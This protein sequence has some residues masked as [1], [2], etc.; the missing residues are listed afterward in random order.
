VVGKEPSRRTS[1][2]A[3]GHQAAKVAAQHGKPA[4]SGGVG[5]LEVAIGQL[6]RSAGN[7]ATVALLRKG[8]G[9]SDAPAAAKG[10]PL[11][12][13]LRQGVEALSGLSMDHVRVHYNSPVPAQLQAL[14]YSQGSDIHL[15]PGQERHLPHEAWHVVQQAQGRVRPASAEGGKADEDPVLA[16]EA[17]VMGAK[18]ALGPGGAKGATGAGGP[19]PSP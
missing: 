1:D 9:D 14:A 5:A 13:N 16:H 19:A 8:P 6:Q 17:D 4:A 2:A 3:S 10:Q 7:R 18:A 15:A 11:P 12:D